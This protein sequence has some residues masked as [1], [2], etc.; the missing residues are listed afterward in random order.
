MQAQHVGQEG[1]LE[2]IYRVID[3]ITRKDRIIQNGVSAAL[4]QSEVKL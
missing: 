4:N 1:E 2:Q 3:L